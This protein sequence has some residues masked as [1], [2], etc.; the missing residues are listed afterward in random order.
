VLPDV[1]EVLPLVELAFSEVEQALKRTSDEH[2]T[3]PVSPEISL[4]FIEKE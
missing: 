2:S 1:P 4:R 3:A